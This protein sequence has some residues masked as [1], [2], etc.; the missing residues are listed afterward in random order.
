MHNRDLGEL[1]FDAIPSGKGWMIQK[2][3]VRQPLMDLQATGS[4]LLAPGAGQ[5]TEIEARLTTSNLGGL[6]TQFGYDSEIAGGRMDLTSSWSWSGSPTEFSLL[7]L[8]GLASVVITVMVCGYRHSGWS[9]PRSNST[10][11][12]MKHAPVQFVRGRSSTLKTRG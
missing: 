4:W 10:S 1:E 5:S 9:N 7:Q 6:L 11:P 2:L 3:N 8:D 12:L